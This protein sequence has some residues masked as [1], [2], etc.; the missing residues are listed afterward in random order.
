MSSK[1]HPQDA[2]RRCLSLSVSMLHVASSQHQFTYRLHMLVH[3]LSYNLQ[4]SDIGYGACDV[5]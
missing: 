5:M 4:H 1:L 3:E 2:A